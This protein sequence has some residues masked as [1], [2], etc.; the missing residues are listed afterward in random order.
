MCGGGGGRPTLLPPPFLHPCFQILLLYDISIYILVGNLN[1]KCVVIHFPL[2][3]ENMANMCK[4]L[5]AA[6]PENGILGVCFCW[7]F[8]QALH[9]QHDATPYGLILPAM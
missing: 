3:S 1:E 7:M 9:V 6:R 2:D 5:S 4:L 8:N